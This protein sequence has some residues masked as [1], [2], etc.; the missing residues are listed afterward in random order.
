MNNGRALLKASNSLGSRR[1]VSACARD[2]TSAC[3]QGTRCRRSLPT[4]RSKVASESSLAGRKV[5]RYEH[6]MIK[7][8]GYAC[9][10]QP[11]L[12]CGGTG[13]PWESPRCWSTF[14]AQ[15]SSNRRSPTTYLVLDRNSLRS[16]FTALVVS[17]TAGTAGTRSR[18]TRRNS[19]APT[20]LP[21]IGSWR[22][23]NG[24][25][26]VQGRSQSHL[27]LGHLHGLAA[28]P[29]AW[30]WREAISSPPLMWSSPRASN[31]AGTAWAFRKS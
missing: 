4:S 10:S 16:L 19:H 26:A 6:E 14:T 25:P 8:W 2:G 27:S 31:M 15:A 24:S 29:S 9:G 7:E 5:V 30:A 18:R 3:R 20:P 11:A 12:Y 17:R 23:S 28:A 13:Q 1:T 22:R 21:S